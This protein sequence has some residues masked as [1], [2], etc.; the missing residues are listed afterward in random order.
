MNNFDQDNFESVNPDSQ[1]ETAFDDCESPNTKY[2]NDW[3]RKPNTPVNVLLV[4]LKLGYL[5]YLLCLL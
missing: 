1:D 3:R 5:L 2:H 4:R